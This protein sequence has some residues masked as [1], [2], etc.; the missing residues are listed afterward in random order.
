MIGIKLKQRLVNLHVFILSLKDIRNIG[1]NYLLTK[2]NDSLIQILSAVY[3]EY[4]WLPWKFTRTSA[5]YLEDLKGQR[6]LIDRIAKQ[7]NVKEMSDWYK[8]SEKV[9][10]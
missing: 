9:L 5:T 4:E 2:Y 3:P 7:Y 1:G 8:V 10:L 6:Q